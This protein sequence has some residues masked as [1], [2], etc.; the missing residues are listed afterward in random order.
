MNIESPRVSVLLPVYN[1]APFLASS[2][3]SI[4]SQSFEDF[5]LLILNDGSTDDSAAIIRSYSDRRIRYF[6][7]SNMGLPATLNGGARL[8]RGEFLFRQDQ[9]DLSYPSRLTRQ[10]S[11]LDEH[12]DIAMLG[13]WARIFI[14]SDPAAACRY[15]RHPTTHAAVALCTTFDSTFVHSSVAM[16]RS[17]FE[18]LGGYSCDPMRQPP[19]DFELWSRMC[20]HY[21]VANLAEVLVDYR[22]VASSMSRVFREDFT[23]RMLRISAENLRYWLGGSPFATFSDKLA[24]IYHL[25]GQLPTEAADG[26]MIDGAL[27][28]LGQALGS[29][30][31]ILSWEYRHQLHRIRHQL[32]RNY[33]LGR[34]RRNAFR[35]AVKAVFQTLKKLHG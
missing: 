16:R 13:S 7:H 24:R 11:Y 26:P 20:R 5:E 2:I 21:Q 27:A 29:C 28:Q 18:A 34:S 35:L 10:V 31:N 22:E 3:D 33:W 9:D 6:E 19:E 17:A 12:P 8:A 15:H 4:L 23:E 1:G 25:D 32:I 14:D 30:G